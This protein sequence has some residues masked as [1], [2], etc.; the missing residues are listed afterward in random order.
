MIIEGWR[1]KEVF[2]GIVDTALDNAEGVMDDVEEAAR[3]RCPELKDLSQERPDGWAHAEVSFTPQTGKN[4]GKLMQFS[5]DKRWTGRKRGDL[6]RT[7]RRVS[8]RTKGNIRV[9]A[10]NFKIY[11]AFMVERGTKKTK[12]QPFLRPAFQE[13]KSQIVNRIQNGGT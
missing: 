6:K 10:G 2:Q 8:K 7:I 13:I 4:K 12:M 3:R 1:A 11:W 9:Y 5:T